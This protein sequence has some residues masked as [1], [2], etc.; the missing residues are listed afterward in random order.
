MNLYRALTDLAHLVFGFLG[1]ILEPWLFTTIFL[2]KQVLDW[3]SGKERWSET[4][5]D[6][7]EYS[8]GLIIGF[9]LRALGIFSLS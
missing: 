5:R 4:S 2:V 6:I 1:A 8:T 9:I 7:I 3:R